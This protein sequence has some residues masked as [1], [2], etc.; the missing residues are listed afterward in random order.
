[1]RI[2]LVS[3]EFSKEITAVLWLNEH[4]LDI[5]CVRLKPY[6]LDGRVLVDV[7]QPAPGSPSRCQ[8]GAELGYHHTVIELW[9]LSD[10]RNEAGE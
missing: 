5:C 9:G 8:C 7:Q 1:M 2:V 3:A 10:W 4:S 6:N